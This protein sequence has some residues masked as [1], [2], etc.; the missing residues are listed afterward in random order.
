[1]PLIPANVAVEDDI[2]PTVDDITSSDSKT[3][4]ND[5]PSDENLISGSDSD[6]D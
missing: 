1:M 6:D 3:E 2:L 5:V 4:Q